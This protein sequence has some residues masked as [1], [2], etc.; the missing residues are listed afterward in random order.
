LAFFSTKSIRKTARPTCSKLYKREGA[1]V[2]ESTRA[3]PQFKKL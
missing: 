2:S 1:I 3:Q